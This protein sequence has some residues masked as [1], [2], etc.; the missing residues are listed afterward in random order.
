MKRSPI[1]L[2][3]GSSYLFRAFHALPP[4]TTSKNH[5]TGAIKGV[6]SMIRRL[7]QDYP[8]APIVVVFDAK[9]K[10]FRHELYEEYK[11]HRPPM[12]EDLACQ[13]DPI[14]Q[15]I[16]AMGLP[17]LVEEGVEAD[18]VIGT[19]AREATEKGLDAIISTGDKDMAQLVNGHITLFNSMTDTFMDRDGVIEKFGVPPEQ[20][21]DYLALVGDT[22]DNIPGVNKCGPKTA[23]KWLKQYEDLDNLIEHAD[24]VKGKIGDNLREAAD[25]LPRSRE[26][27]TIR[28]DLDLDIDLHDLEPAE[29]DNNALLELFRT[30]EFKTW[31][32]ELAPGEE[33]VAAESRPE[34]DPIDR[35]NYEVIYQQ[36]DFDRWLKALEKA[37][38]FAFDTE[39]TSLNY[40][41]ARIVGVSF[42][43]EPGSA[44]YVPLAHDYMGAPDQLDR[45]QVL[46]AL[47]PLL[48]DPKRAKVGQNLKYDMNVLANHGISLRGVAEDTMLESYVLNSV[49]TRHDMDSLSLKYLGHAPISFESIA[50]KGAKQLTFNQIALEEA[51]PYAAEDADITLRL[52]HKLRPQ[53]S[54]EKSLDRVY[55]EIDMPLVP[56][57]AHMERRGALV[58]ADRLR[59]QSQELAESM[60]KIEEQAFEEAGEK[61]NLG[62]PKQL[63]AILYDKL[64][65]PVIKKTPKG[66]PSTAEA[67]LQDLA[68]DHA[69][70]RLIV[71]YRGMSK[72]K[73][74]YTDRL[75]ELINPDTGR[76]HTSYHQAV[77]ATGRLSSSDPNLQNIPIRSPEGRRIR[78]AFIAPKG[79]R[80]MAADYSQIE[81]RIMAHLSGDKGLLDAFANGEDIHRA[82]AAE[83]FGEKLGDV[84]NEQRRRAKAINFGLIYGMSAFG[85]S[86]QIGVERNT[87]QSYIDRYFERYPGV[88]EYMDRVR[89][90]AHDQGYVETLFGR[91]LYLPDISSRNRQIRQGA[92]RTAI[93]APMQGTA[94]DIIKIAMADVENWLES[95]QLDA[96][97]VMQVHDELILEVAEKDLEDVRK[98]LEE[99]MSKAAKLDVPLLVEAG[100]GENWD[101]AH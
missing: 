79:Y 83:V 56:V 38:L 99:R 53:L 94:A 15:I 48:E 2:V 80:V 92:E 47:K 101:E 51:G 64:G 66:A 97:M 29:P 96:R 67:V 5:P 87:A 74:T 13:I 54:Q 61:F 68:M 6:V 9:G 89:G 78:Q 98:G 40:M 63:Q 14:H 95:S 30:Y 62:S 88:L 73:S 19:L 35:D 10:T 4:L 85:L 72:L 21:I 41:Q 77:T 76:I 90:L 7:Q 43:V 59:K 86:R 12:P 82:T 31:I 27:A 20:I 34:E 42:A 49:A 26:L 28:T 91:R 81:L 11:A 16:R 24:E 70:P 23:V 71:D 58:D 18:D 1:I 100:D 84:S 46:E 36:T 44:A 50:G 25:Y 17:L 32:A 22:S 60:Q 93:N 8:D 3:D 37:D 33:E 57:L 65:L 69:L 75:P 55:R 52:H 45:D 39:T